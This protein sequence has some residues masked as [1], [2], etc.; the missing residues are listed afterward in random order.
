[1]TTR[2]A[3]STLYFAQARTLLLA[4]GATFA[5]CAA[6]GCGDTDAAMTPREA[7]DRYFA[8]I[9]TGAP[10]MACSVLT[11]D[12]VRQLRTATDMPFASCGEM[13][14]AIYADLDELDQQRLLTV[15]A[16]RETVRGTRAWITDKDVYIPGTADLEDAGPGRTEL[17]Q[18]DGHWTITSLGDA[19]R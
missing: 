16:H 10:D 9:A 19:L 7:V 12:A 6:T 3:S 18:R 11:R 4:C 1:M 15:R 13:I 2:L 14:D 17:E 8:G 5:G